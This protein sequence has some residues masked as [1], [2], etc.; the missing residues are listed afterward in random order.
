MIK[1]EEGEEM[2]TRIVSGHRV[3]IDYRK[4]NLATKKDHYL[5]PFTDQILEKLAGQEFYCFL[6]GYSRYNQM[7]VREHDQEKTTFT[8]AVDTYAFKRMPFD[9]CNAPETFQRCMN[10][11][12]SEFIGEYLEIFLDDFSFFGISFDNCLTNLE[13]VLKSCVQNNLVLSWQK[14][15]FIVQ[16]GI[17]LGHII[18]KEGIKV[19]EA[20]V[21]VIKNLPL[22]QTQKQ[23]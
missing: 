12:F 23:L 2:Q 7:A 19:D 10:A 3:C 16:E 18:S 13:Q 22:P 21:E 9:L 20:K 15:H 14:S 5:L 17:V 6:D 8:C 4:L 1:S 11:V